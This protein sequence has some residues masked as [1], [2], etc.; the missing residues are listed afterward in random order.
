MIQLDRCNFYLKQVLN[1]P[2]TIFA[3]HNQWKM[4][5]NY[6]SHIARPGVQ[7]ST[8]LQPLWVIV[9]NIQ[10]TASEKTTLQ[11][12]KASRSKSWAHKFLTVLNQH[13]SQSG[14]E[15]KK[16]YFHLT[17]HIKMLSLNE[18][19][20]KYLGPISKYKI[21]QKWDQNQYVLWGNHLYMKL[22]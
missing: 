3:L 13:I 21:W 7:I 18:F 1:R 10:L 11:K 8:L 12:T 6:N 4:K 9:P 22:S 2:P 17:I 20:C 5:Q 14:T 15:T 19:H 16:H